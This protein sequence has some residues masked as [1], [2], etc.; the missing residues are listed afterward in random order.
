MNLEQR[1]KAILELA[2]FTGVDVSADFLKNTSEHFA[3]AGIPRIHSL[4]EGIYKPAGEK[5]AFSVL[6]QSAILKDHEIYPDEVTFQADGSWTFQYSAKKTPL[7]AE[8]NKSLFACLEDNVPVLVVVKVTHGSQEGARYRILGPAL[9]EGFDPGSRRFIM[10]G[11]SAPLVDQVIRYS[12]LESAA[13]IDIRSRLIMPFGMGQIRE[14][15][16][17]DKEAREKAFRRILLE[18]YRAQCAVCQSKFLLRDE[19]KASLVEADAAHIISVSAAGP[20]DPRNGLSLCRRHHWAFDEGL[21]TVT[22]AMMIKVSPAVLRAERRRFDLKE[23]DSES[24]VAP[25]HE[26]CRPHEEAIHWHQ[27]QVFRA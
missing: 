26:I 3:Q 21:F 1:T 20:D 19:G 8:P 17:S 10:R 27:K 23:Y 12:S 5:Y 25:A 16:I 4:I 9:I 6:S 14:S 18:E 24:L 13:L 22:D 2:K 7:E 11:A 15:Y